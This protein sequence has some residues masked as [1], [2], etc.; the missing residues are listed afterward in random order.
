M[1]TH[2]ETT[3]ILVASLLALPLLTTACE[4]EF[5]EAGF[6]DDALFDDASDEDDSQ[7]R[8]GQWTPHPINPQLC[9]NPE[10]E[11]SRPP[12]AGKCEIDVRL[13]Q[14]KFVTGQG[15]S[16]GRAEMSTKVTATAPNGTQTVASVPELVYNVGQK[17][18]HNMSLGTYM[19]NAGASKNISV[20]AEFTEHDNG[21]VNGGDDIGNA[22]TNVLLECDPVNGQPTFTK[23]VGAAPLCGDNQCNG[24]ASAKVEVM[25]ADADY[26]GVE[27]ED[28]FTPEP[29][30]EVDKGKEGVA[31]LLYFHYDDDNFTT[32][33]QS[34]GTNLSKHYASYD[35][36]ALVMDNDT[37]NA[38]NT[39]AQA[40]KQADAVFEP[41]RDGI[42]DAMRHLT[43]LGYRFD[44]KTHAHGYK[45]GLSDS[46]FETLVG[47]NITGDWLETATAPNLI[48]TARGG[49]PIVALWGTTCYQ[50]RQIDSWETVGAIV[51]SGAVDV[52]FYPNAWI[53]YWDAW[54]AG[55]PYRTS[56]DDSVTPLVVGA[57]QTLIAADGAVAPFWCVSP[58]TVLGL[59]ICAEDYFNNDVGPNEAGYNIQ[60]VYDH[61]QSGAA[62]MANASVRMF[63]GA[64]LATFGGGAAVWP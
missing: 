48:G 47:S 39:S 31:L 9:E 4:A 17:Q 16:E 29:C 59:N 18:R 51:A 22:C 12:V 1:T 58:N 44:V 13:I 10:G 55:T 6:D 5:D 49:V 36:V 64:Q 35:Y 21:G 52:N 54:V 23:V 8:A 11:P 34:L 38:N 2:H 19:V 42:L 30:D 41:S 33:A 45:S 26:D 40:F 7:F 27:N 46:S 15:V 32:L 3:R 53:N 28:D 20:C 60:A 25:R 57:S 63:T 43:A 14:T 61:G 50:G 24:S 37:S 56:V 62:N